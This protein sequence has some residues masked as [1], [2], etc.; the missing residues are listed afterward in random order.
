LGCPGNNACERTVKGIAVFLVKGGLAAGPGQ[1]QSVPRRLLG[2]INKH[3]RLSFRL[4]DVPPGP[5]RLVARVHWGEGPE[6]LV[7]SGAFRVVS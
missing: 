1:V 6:L 3:G 7:I 5:H 2:R 4:P